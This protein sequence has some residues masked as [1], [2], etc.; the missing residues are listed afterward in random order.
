M[1]SKPWF[2]TRDE[3]EVKLRLT[4]GKKEVKKRQKGGKIEVELR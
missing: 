1:V 2:E 4:K 3:A